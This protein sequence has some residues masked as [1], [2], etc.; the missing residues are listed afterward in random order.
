MLHKQPISRAILTEM[1]IYTLL[2]IALLVFS[3]TQHAD[4]RVIPVHTEAELKDAI[5]KAQPGDVISMQ[6][7]VWK[8]QVIKFHGQGTK[9]KPIVLKA[10]TAGKVSLEGTSAIM[11]S[12]KNLIVKD[13]Y[14]KNGYTPEEAVI[15]F[16]NSPD[17]VANHC[18]VTGTVI[19]EFTQ[20]D[21]HRKDH[22]IEF[23]GRNNELD[24]CY[25]AG[26]SNEGPTLKVYLNNN[27]H[28]NNY[29]KIHHN[30]FGPRPRKGGPKAETMQL[31][32]STTSMTPSYTQVTHNLFEKC[33]GEVEIISSKS[34][35]NNFSHNVFLESEGSVVTR[36][37]NYATINANIF[38]AND[39]PFVGGIRVINTGHWITNNYFYGLKG[40]EFRS[41][42]AVMNGIP[43]SPLNRYNQVTDVVIAHNSWID[44]RQ[45]IHWSVGANLD[46]ADVL[47][48]SEI[49]SARP[50]RLIFANNLIAHRA[51][52]SYPFKLY[53]QL[54][55]V[56]FKNN[57][58]IAPKP[59]DS[60][61][62]KGLSFKTW[63]S[64]L[65]Q[66]ADSSKFIAITDQSLPLYRGFSFED[67]EN[68]LYGKR[69]NEKT[70]SIGAIISPIAKK[71]QQIDRSIYGT[72]WYQPQTRLA[73]NTWKA[74]N[75]TEFLE[76]LEKA[77]DGDLIQLTPGNYL[78]DQKVQIEKKIRVEGLE[79]DADVLVQL[80]GASTSF[81][82]APKGI[83]TLKNLTLVGT[84]EQD[85]FITLDQH[86][87]MAYGLQLQDVEIRNFRTVLNPSKSSFADEIIIKNCTIS[88]SKNGL[89]F[90]KE[91]DDKGDY[92]VEFLTITNS[93]FQNISHELIN[94]YRGGYDESTIGG[95]LTFENNEVV[96]CGGQD[97]DELLINTYGIVNVSIEN[98]VF[99]DNPIKLVAV[100]WGAKGQQPINNELKNSGDIVIEEKLKQKLVY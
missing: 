18:R 29:H 76:Q 9:E 41:A 87:S 33:N 27:R 84:G 62:I 32:A 64:N 97:P 16:R 22:W 68:D 56:K 42:L 36:H 78:I 85:L 15:I 50:K 96:Q 46:Q 82:L 5:K 69:R 71:H 19:E 92:N 48:V 39:N 89:L 81:Q 80:T 94:Y 75:T 14:F 77:D 17:S 91:T 24:H 21:R 23:Y 45:P 52:S 88:D 74:T 1:K 38:I 44:C 65:M 43:K 13:L 73:T 83:L 37:G 72:T 8:D 20:P 35:Y 63:T 12:G 60:L 55:G 10:A 57:W 79:G 7:G 61:T 26:K 34:N 86:M 90:N 59:N 49:R 31:G 11:I 53:D 95:V 47:P 28:I 98:N 99:K 25:I 40:K 66:H 70:N 67:I 30:H 54:D 58:F 4:Y 3:C 93:R 100:L 6:E 2:L 51:D